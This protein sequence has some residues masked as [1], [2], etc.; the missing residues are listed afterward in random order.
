MKI[1]RNALLIHGFALLHLATAVA[2][3]MIGVDDALFL[4]LLTMTLIA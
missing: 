3:R 2:C 4:T 1:S